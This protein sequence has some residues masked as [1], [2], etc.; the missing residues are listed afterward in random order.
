MGEEIFG[1]IL[2]VLSVADL[3]TALAFIRER[4]KPLALYLFSHD[5]AAQRRVIETTSSGGVCINDVVMQLVGPQLPFGGVGAS[6]MGAYHGRT[7]FETFSHRKS[8]LVKGT[9]MELPLRYPPY[10]RFYQRWLRRF[11]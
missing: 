11:T 5:K 1:P 9:R 2:P 10:E 3:D 8:V 7:G 6:G 4:P